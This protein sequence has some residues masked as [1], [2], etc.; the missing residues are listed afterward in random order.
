MVTDTLK[1]DQP[2]RRC[3]TVGRFDPMPYEVDF[4]GFLSNTVAAHWMERLRVQLTR[5]HFPDFDGNKLENLSVIVQTY[6]QYYKPIRYGDSVIGSAWISNVTKARWWIQFQFSSIEASNKELFIDAYQVGVFID[7][8]S[9]KP[10]R[11]PDI[12]STIQ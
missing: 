4:T 12:L 8:K 9:Y 7:Y 11:I 3:L 1:P 5:E 10:V 6:T 2:S